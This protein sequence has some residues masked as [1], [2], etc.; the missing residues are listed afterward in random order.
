MFVSILLS[1]IL[2]L[3]RS[4]MGGQEHYGG[5]GACTHLY[6]P[7][8]LTEAEME[9]RQVFSVAPV[10]QQHHKLSTSRSWDDFL[11]RCS[12][13]HYYYLILVTARV[14][15]WLQVTGCVDLLVSEKRWSPA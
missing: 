2:S 11:F 7:G 8:S 13:L 1:L 3:H 15:V 14:Q 4:I 9:S 12:F 6:T 10:G 5:A